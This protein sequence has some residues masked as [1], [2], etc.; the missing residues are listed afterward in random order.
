MYIDDLK[1]D[2]DYTERK[3]IQV[4]EELEELQKRQVELKWRIQK[5]EQ[6]K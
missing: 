1:K 2:L 5:E 4:K 3:I 6:N